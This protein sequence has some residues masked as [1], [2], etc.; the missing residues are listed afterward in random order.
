MMSWLEGLMQIC[1]LL[2]MPINTLMV[3]RRCMYSKCSIPSFVLDNL[4]ILRAG[5]TLHPSWTSA[6]GRLVPRSSPGLELSILTQQY[7]QR[8]NRSL[9]KDVEKEIV[10]TQQYHQRHNR[11]LEKDVEK[12][13]SGYFELALLS[14]LREPLRWD[15]QCLAKGCRH[16]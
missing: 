6:T 3:N 5:S 2:N 4:G 11:S 16:I 14:I 15:I 1:M 12:E 10:L 7:H 13:I 8:H 9:E